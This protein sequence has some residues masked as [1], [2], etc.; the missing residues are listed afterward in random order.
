MASTPGTVNPAGTAY[1]EPPVN[2][3]SYAMTASGGSAGLGAAA[4]GVATLP[5]LM[6][7]TW[8]VA[9]LGVPAV[10][11][12]PQ[13]VGPGSNTLGVILLL[14]AAFLAGLALA[15]TA[16]NRK[17]PPGAKPVAVSMGSL[18]TFVVLNLLGLTV[19]TLGLALLA[20][21]SPGFHVAA[22]VGAGLEVLAVGVGVRRHIAA[23]RELNEAPDRPAARS[24]ATGF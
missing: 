19:Y 1:T 7:M 4:A 10:S 11:R 13:P 24:V 18:V 20:Q 17:C 6:T 8:S 2:P 14:G 12:S 5:A 9:L 22:S 16:L 21:G 15:F 3:P 23:E